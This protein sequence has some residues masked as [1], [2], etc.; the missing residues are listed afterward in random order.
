M[1]DPGYEQIS[2]NEGKEFGD[3]EEGGFIQ[4]KQLM[5]HSR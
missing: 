3:R 1:K 2:S 4:H 5:L